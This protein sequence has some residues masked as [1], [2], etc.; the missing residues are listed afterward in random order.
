MTEREEGRCPEREAVIATIDGVPVTL[1]EYERAVRR[2]RPRVLNHFFPQFKTCETPEFWTTS[3]AGEIPLELLKQTALDE[4]VMV[5]IRQ[6]I[7]KD[8]DVVQDISHKAFLE[9]LAAENERRAKAIAGQQVVYG[10]VRYS[11]DAYFEYYM[12]RLAAAVKQKLEQE[13]RRRATC[14]QTL[15]NYYCSCR[16]ELY[17]NPGYVKVYSI[18]VSYLNADRQIDPVAQEHTRKRLEQAKARLEWGMPFIE[19]TQDYADQRKIQELTF[20]LENDR[21]NLRSPVAR[22]AAGLRVGEISE[23]VEENGSLYLLCC[24]EKTEPYTEYLPYE[25]IRDRVLNDYIASKY[26]QLIQAR[27]AEAQF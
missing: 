13:E 7:A 23:I 6:M 9:Q 24:V 25:Q 17:L 14:E 12:T 4:S 10:P 8:Y 18:T 1:A 21:H 5:K 26:E 16:T 22:T 20:Y 19:I 27:W 15:W 2:N 3:F 11:E